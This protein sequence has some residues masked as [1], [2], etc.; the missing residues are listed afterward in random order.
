MSGQETTERIRQAAVLSR[1]IAEKVKLLRRGKEFIGLCPFHGEKSPSF[2]VNDQKGLYYCFG[3]GAKG[4]VFDFT[5]QSLGLDFKESVTFLAE[6]FGVP[7]EKFA[8]PA[9]G[10]NKKVKHL[11][12]LLENAAQWYHGNLV[13]EARAYCANRGLSPE[14]IEKFQIGFAG[15]RTPELWQFLETKGFSK[16]DCVDAGLLGEDGS[17]T[18]ERFRQ[19]LLFP[20]RTK[21][22]AVVGFGG[23]T[24]VGDPAKYLN[25][26]ET[27]L[28]HKGTLL[29]GYGESVHV[30]KASGKL[31]V[32]EGYMDVIALHQ[33][34]VPYA[35]APLGTG[36]SEQQLQDAWQ[37]APTPLIC[38]DGDEAGM[39]AAR[40]LLD[41]ALP[42]I[43]PGQSLLFLTLPQGEDPDTF[44]RQFGADGLAKLCET[45]V[46]LSEFLWSHLL[47]QSDQSTPEG[48]AQIRTRL[49]EKIDQIQSTVVR[50]EYDAFFKERWAD[51][52]TPKKT[53]TPYTQG[54]GNFKKQ[55]SSHRGP[56]KYPS[57]KGSRSF[58]S[59]SSSSFS[60][61]STETSS[62][63]TSVQNPHFAHLK[64]R[65]LL[66]TLINH[67]WLLETFA[68]EIGIISISPQ[69]S[70]IK[71]EI[72][73]LFFK[74]ALDKEDLKTQLV[75]GG[76]ESLIKVAM[77]EGT[78][79][80]GSFARPETP[81]AVVEAG[82]RELLASFLD[83]THVETEIK[84][85]REALRE[86][87]SS[88]TWEHLKKLLKID[89]Q[90]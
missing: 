28:F 32:V 49:R 1:V 56:D 29:F 46:P 43:K 6:K 18:F 64:E 83:K 13:P 11:Q 27:V 59:Q 75:R 62:D 2:T 82:L 70:P 66:A 23:R 54:K 35:V 3:C 88:A 85:A 50:S 71:D 7:L 25:S 17:R 79:V 5:Q 51:I 10:Q 30:A 4:D 48:R 81:Q 45:A 47:S 73:N 74:R 76:S 44:V 67:P 8:A 78:Y 90:L 38:F 21:R 69:F 37:L 15:P 19:R 24:L 60:E 57:S 40:R 77:S 12:S 52:F 65:L 36:F 42:L 34:G 22:G 26:P 39:R 84:K 41:L 55:S 53:F 58:S 86:D 89:D 61:L 63:T 31:I 14:T 80:H 9:S 68:E 87:F 16:K 33:A 72:L 20:I